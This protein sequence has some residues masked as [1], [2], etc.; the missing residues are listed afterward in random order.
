M[1]SPTLLL[2]FEIFFF[3][4]LGTLGGF[5]HVL[6]L[7]EMI[8]AYCNGYMKN[9]VI[10]SILCGIVP[11]LFGI[12]I[13]FLPETSLFYLMKDNEVAAR[14]SMIYFRGKNFD[15]EPEINDFKVHLQ[16]FILSSSNNLISS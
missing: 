7:I 14:K 6:T 10:I 9:V 8:F 4:K 11:I 3:N 12:S 13:I 15:V 1:T 2:L 5:F 16:T